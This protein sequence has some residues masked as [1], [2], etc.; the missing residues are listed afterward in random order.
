VS[1]ANDSHFVNAGAAATAIAAAREAY[2]GAVQ[3]ALKG[4]I[5]AGV[6]VT[7]LAQQY[8]DC[9]AGYLGK[10]A[11]WRSVGLRIEADLINVL[12]SFDRARQA[13]EVLAGFTPPEAATPRALADAIDLLRGPRGAPKGPLQ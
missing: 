10:G 13:H 4:E 6:E 7:S 3:R 5:T 2:E 1:A 11:V 12:A 9:V 8:I